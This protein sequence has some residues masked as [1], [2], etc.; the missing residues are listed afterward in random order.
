L[1]AIP[2]ILAGKDVIGCAQTGTGKTAAY[3]LP[4]LEMMMQYKTRAGAI[5]TLVI[6]P[7]RELALQIDQH[8]E[9]FS[10]FV[11]IS[12][13]PV[14][15]GGD[16][17]A[18]DVQKAA[19]LKGADVVI[20][21][22]GRLIAHLKLGYLS[23]D[24]LKFLVLDE[25]DRML[26][27]GFYDDIIQIIDYLPEKRQNLLFSATMPPE[28]RR[29]AKKILDDPVEIN[30]ALAK[31]AEGIL[32]TIYRVEER[33]KTKLVVHLITGKDVPSILI[34]CSTKKSVKIL[35]KE[36]INLGFQTG[37]IHSDLLQ[38]ERENVLLDFKNRKLQI[39]VATDVISR[40][41][42]IENIDLVI[43]YDTPQDAEDYVHRVGRTARAKS[44]GVAITLVTRDEMR[45]ISRIEDLIG[46]KIF[47]S[48]LPPEIRN[49]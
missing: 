1:K 4:L 17:S 28:I 25:A 27:M 33:L 40:G 7:T 3:I 42:D 16:G 21:T 9:G 32:Q 2:A 34:F 23:M 14:Y 8:F 13:I 22:P 10:Y 35:E 46:Y 39:L 6:A 29:L 5:T 11:P 48:P 36:L 47:Q 15:G 26:D 19:M 37:A 44:T 24:H 20:A 49:S 12:S 43:N 38:K 45:T 31:P 18:W 30:I 41:I